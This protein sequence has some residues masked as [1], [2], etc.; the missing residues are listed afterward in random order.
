MPKAGQDVLS[1]PFD[2]EEQKEVRSEE[3]LRKVRKQLREH[4]KA[5]RS[6]E[7]Q[8]RNVLINID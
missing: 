6:N 5:A 1:V 7:N 2:A 8:A 3:R 4:A